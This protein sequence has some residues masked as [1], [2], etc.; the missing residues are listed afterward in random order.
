MEIASQAGQ[1][2]KQG[3]G[4]ELALPE[5]SRTPDISPLLGLDR[6]RA[7][8]QMCFASLFA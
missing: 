3:Q 1:I 7:A 5:G 8:A 6:I 4:L 2:P